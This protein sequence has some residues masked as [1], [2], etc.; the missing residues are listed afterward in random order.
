MT[1]TVWRKGDSEPIHF[2]DLGSDVHFNE[3]R[4]AV[5][6][7]LEIKRYGS[8]F[9]VLLKTI[10]DNASLSLKQTMKLETEIM[11]II[12]EKKALVVKPKYSVSIKSVEIA[13]SILKKILEGCRKAIEVEGNL[14]WVSEFYDENKAIIIIEE[15]MNRLK[16]KG[17]SL[18][19]AMI[20]LDDKETHQ[21]IA[22]GQTGGT[23]LLGASSMKRSINKTVIN[24]F[25][26]LVALVAIYSQVFIGEGMLD[27]FIK[28]KNGEIKIKYIH[29]LFKKILDQTYGVILYREQVMEI[30]HIIGGMLLKKAEEARKSMIRQ[31]TEKI[32]VYR[33]AFIK[34][35]VKK[36]L[37]ERDAERT[38]GL[39]AYFAQYAISKSLATKHATYAYQTAYLK[40]HY[41][42]EFIALNASLNTQ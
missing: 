36:G 28:R 25:E 17:K 8:R 2:E 6:N 33:N 30:L 3:M 27:D 9:P 22:S 32:K 16:G 38:F 31:E 10:Q 24:N 39:L 23:Y 35:A 15:I 21:L 26:D 29:P 7:S 19:M 37:T 20:P 18:D 42:K 14:F 41:P 4:N 34:G 1:F 40:V 13:I 11:T 12:D 5:H